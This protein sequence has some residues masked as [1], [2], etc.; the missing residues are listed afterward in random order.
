[1]CWPRPAGASATSRS[2]PP[3][4]RSASPWRRGNSWP[5][6]GVQA[7]VVS[8]PC[9]ELFAAQPDSLSQGG[10]GH[11]AARRRRGG[12][13][14]GLGALARRW[15]H[16]H[17]H[18]RLR[19]LGAGAQAVRALRHHGRPDRGGG[20]RN[21][22]ASPTCNSTT[23]D[24]RRAR[25]EGQARA[26]ARR[27]QRAG[28]GRQGHRR[29]ATGAPRAGPARIWPSAAPG[30]SSSRISA[31]P[32]AGPIR[33]TQ[34]QARG[35]QA[36]RA[37]RQAGRVR[38]RLHRRAGGQ[39]GGLAARTATSPCWRTCASTRARRRTIRPSPRSWPSSATSSSATPSP[40]RIARMPPPMPSRVCCRPMPGRC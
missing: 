24:Y 37:A 7:A 11:C 10:A 25:P 29:D 39:G 33:S 16:V 34:L 32:R 9:W 8:M 21:W 15:R 1:M 14:H 28:Q 3:A 6:S 22:W 20:Q 38:H 27:P 35:R 12:D 19:R 4:R 23:E 31:G 18:E 30:S 17:R 36:G 40:P 2:W 26:G 13:R 5:K